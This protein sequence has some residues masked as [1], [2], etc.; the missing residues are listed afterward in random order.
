MAELPSGLGIFDLTGK[1]A[2]VT[3]AGRGLGRAMAVALASAGADLALTSRTRADLED[4]AAAVAAHGRAALPVPADVTQPEQVEALVAA[5]LARFGHIDILVNNAGMNVRKT[6][7]DLPL[8]EFD[9]VLNLNLRAYFLV[10]RTVGRHMVERRYGRVINVTSILAAIAL[11]NQAA[12]AT[13]KGGVT[14]LSRVLAIE[15]APH[16]ITVNCLGPTYFETNLTRPLYQD[17]ERK[18]F[19]ESR[20]PMGRWGQVEELAGAVIFLASDAAGFITGQTVF[21]D[22]GWLAW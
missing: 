7:L 6:A 8:E 14:Q 13:S 10:A 2:L 15:W 17:P 19:I 11:P 9:Q 18:T 4:A 21:V 1:V 16:N 5:A 22:G 20:T 12:Y 3:G